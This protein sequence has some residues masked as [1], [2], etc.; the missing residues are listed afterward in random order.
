MSSHCLFLIFQIKMV[1]NNNNL[2]FH[3][4]F[5]N[6]RAKPYRGKQYT[7]HRSKNAD[8]NLL[9]MVVACLND[10]CVAKSMRTE[11]LTEFYETHRDCQ[12]RN[13]SSERSREFFATIATETYARR[14]ET[15]AVEGNEVEEDDD[16][17]EEEEEAKAV[18][19]DE[20]LERLLAGNCTQAE[21]QPEQPMDIIERAVQEAQIVTTVEW[22]P[23]TL[24]ENAE[25]E[26]ARREQV[27]RPSED[28]FFGGHSMKNVSSLAL[29]GRCRSMESDLKRLRAELEEMRRNAKAVEAQASKVREEEKVLASAQHVLTLAQQRAEL[30]QEEVRAKEEKMREKEEEMRARE[31]KVRVQEEE[32]AAKEEKL[33]VREEKLRQLQDRLKVKSERLEKEKLEKGVMTLHIPIDGVIAGD[34]FV[35]EKA[36]DACFGDI[37]CGHI[38][39]DAAARRLLS[40]RNC[41]SRKRPLTSLAQEADSEEE[42]H[43]PKQAHL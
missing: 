36:D 16:E 28:V 29:K 6:C 22:A 2:R 42:N 11:D 27:R 21:P 43:A 25:E 8:H 14:R 37:T 41:R 30:R 38:K 39:V 9:Q 35:Q 24:L 7:T 23:E 40:W 4:Y 19:S 17:E 18:D 31:E 34:P 3:I 32:A 10:L 20:E 12:T 5:C 33:R 13:L 26:K 1:R 15:V